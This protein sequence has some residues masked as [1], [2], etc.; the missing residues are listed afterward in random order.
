MNIKS[1]ENNKLKM[2][3]SD[4]NLFF[5]GLLFLPI[6]KPVKRKA[7]VLSMYESGSGEKTKK[8]TITILLQIFITFV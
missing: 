8:I 7:A 6:T 5:L 1:T 3:S 2:L 4:L